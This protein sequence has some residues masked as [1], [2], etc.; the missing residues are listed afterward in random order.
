MGDFMLPSKQ[1]KIM[2][3]DMQKGESIQF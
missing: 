1:H 2:V 3:I